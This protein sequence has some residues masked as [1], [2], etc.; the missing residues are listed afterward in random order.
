M[1]ALTITLNYDIYTDY[2][3]TLPFL[4]TNKTTLTRR[5]IN[6]QG[7]HSWEIDLSYNKQLLSWWSANNTVAVY[8]NAFNGEAAGYSLNNS[9]LVSIEFT[10]N[11]SFR[12]SPT[13]SAECD[14]EY[15]SKRQYVNSTFGGYSVLDL[16]LK[17]SL[18]GGKGSLTL[19][20]NNILQSEDRKAIDRNA[21][22]Y[23]VTSLHFYSRYVSLNFA[24]RFGSGKTTRININSGSAE[25]QNR[26]GN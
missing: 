9:G 6:I 26:A 20:G 3:R 24:Y 15:D 1:Q 25:E 2:I 4:D 23:Q 7:A 17:R 13:L 18:F 19:N 21:G 11:N 10:T 22:L 16:G 8:S 5:P 14:F 12:I